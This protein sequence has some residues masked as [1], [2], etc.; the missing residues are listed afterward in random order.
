MKILK[1]AFRGVLEQPSPAQFPG[2]PHQRTLRPLALTPREGFERLA[3]DEDPGEVAVSVEALEDQQNRFR[4][5]GPLG[6]GP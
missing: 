4:I 3:L 2:K 1:A 5:P 6:L